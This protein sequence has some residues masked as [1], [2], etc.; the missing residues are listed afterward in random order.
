MPWWFLPP[1][2]YTRPILFRPSSSRI[3]AHQLYL[4]H[5]VS[6]GSINTTPYSQPQNLLVT[7]AMEVLFLILPLS[8]RKDPFVPKSS[9]VF[10]ELSCSAPTR[11]ICIS[12]LPVHSS[13][14]H[15]LTSA[16]PRET[17][18]SSCVA[19]CLVTQSCLPL[20][21]PMDSSPPSSSAHGDSLS[22][23]TGLGCH[24]LLQGIFPTQGSNPGLQH[25]RWILYRLSHQE[26]SEFYNLLWPLPQLWQRCFTIKVTCRHFQRDEFQWPTLQGPPF[27]SGI[28]YPCL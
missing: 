3:L 16:C 4:S 13:T 8:Q 22:K 18:F 6:P 9:R 20:C 17:S 19:L 10:S 14:Q 2:L 15:H 26:S 28:L 7:A 12:W 21:D 5:L 1:V 11:A 25:W 23:N 24:A 27:T